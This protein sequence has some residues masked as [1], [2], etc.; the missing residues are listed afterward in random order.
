M[1]HLPH[2]ANNKMT[3][4]QILKIRKVVRTQTTRGLLIKCRTN[5]KMIEPIILRMQVGYTLLGHLNL[6]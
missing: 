2:K 5:S 3:R 4:S 1:H 6:T